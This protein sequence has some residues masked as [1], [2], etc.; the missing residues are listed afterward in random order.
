MP[1]PA[2]HT[3]E[4]ASFRLPS[5]AMKLYRGSV[6]VSCKQPR[7]AIHQACWLSSCPVYS[8]EEIIET[9]GLAALGGAEVVVLSSLSTQIRSCIATCGGG[10]GAAARGDCWRYLFGFITIWLGQH[11]AIHLKGMQHRFRVTIASPAAAVHLNA[12]HVVW[13]A[14]VLHQTYVAVLLEWFVSAMRIATMS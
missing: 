5:L 10:G 11:G 7:F 9:E 3:M 6:C 1:N 2:G 14:H 4:P 8:P 13:H 12:L